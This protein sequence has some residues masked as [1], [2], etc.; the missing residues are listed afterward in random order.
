M[1]GGLDGD[2]SIIIDTVSAAIIPAILIFLSTIK[3][4]IEYYY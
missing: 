3:N 4:L 2:V 1:G